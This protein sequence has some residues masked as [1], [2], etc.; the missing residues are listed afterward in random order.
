VYTQWLQSS[1]AEL[2]PGGRSLALQRGQSPLRLPAMEG[3]VTV[4]IFT[5]S[6]AHVWRC[7]TR[8]RSLGLQ[9]DQ[10]PLRS[11]ATRARVTRVFW[12]VVVV[13][14]GGGTHIVVREPV[15]FCEPN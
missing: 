9:R 4:T 1:N 3:G 12:V 10:S 15:T 7:Q 14:G 11:S 8:G 5:G 13:V 2:E 6:C